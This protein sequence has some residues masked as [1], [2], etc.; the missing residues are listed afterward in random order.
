MDASGIKDMF[1]DAIGGTSLDDATVDKLLTDS[2]NLLNQKTSHIGV[3][4]VN[5]YSLL[6]L[7]AMQYYYDLLQRNYDDAAKN[8]KEIT[9]LSQQVTN[10]LIQVEQADFPNYMGDRG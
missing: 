1:L 6:T 8:E 2:L 5:D 3:D 4:F 7:L 10:D 9:R